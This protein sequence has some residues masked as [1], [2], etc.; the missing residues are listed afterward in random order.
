MTLSTSA[1]AVCCCNDF[2]Q[3]IEQARVLNGDDGLVGEIF[4]QINLL[5]S[6]W[7][8]LLAIQG[9]RADE[10]VLLEHWHYDKGPRAR[11]LRRG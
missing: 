8:H 2:A 5:F 1:V 11:E 3:L 4:D 7:P 6:E 9:N 10:F